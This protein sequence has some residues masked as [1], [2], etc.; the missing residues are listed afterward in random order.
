MGV[1]IWTVENPPRTLSKGRWK[2]DSLA[3]FNFP[4]VFPRSVVHPCV[5]ALSPNP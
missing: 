1:R 3:F 5:F 2:C 4:S